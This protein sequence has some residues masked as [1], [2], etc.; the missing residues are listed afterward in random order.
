MLSFI[1]R[2]AGKV[3]DLAQCRNLP[4]LWH[5]LEL[6]THNAPLPN[7]A[8]TVCG[9]K[10]YPAACEGKHIPNLSINTGVYSV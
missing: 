8:G 3:S 10:E 7:Q 6:R 1:D 5:S 9:A 4:V 2:H